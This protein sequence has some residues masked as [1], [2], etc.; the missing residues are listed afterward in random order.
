MF[1]LTLVL[2][3]LFSSACFIYRSPTKDETAI[4]VLPPTSTCRTPCGLIIDNLPA[5]HC[6][7][8]SKYEGE[9]VAAYAATAGDKNVCEELKG[10]RLVM[11]DSENGLWKAGHLWVHGATVCDG[12]LTFLGE[13]PSTRRSALA[14]E[15]GH[16]LE[17]RVAGSKPSAM[18]QH[19]GWRERGYCAAI[20]NSSSLDIPCEQDAPPYREKQRAAH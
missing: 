8:L 15:V 12:A 6:D 16:V 5:G 18:H 2:L 11:V 1:R 14:H 19:T 13:D 17:C 7:A 10:W 9:V 20:Q 3:G 4:P